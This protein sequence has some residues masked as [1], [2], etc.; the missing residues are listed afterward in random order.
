MTLDGLVTLFALLV[1]GGVGVG[2]AMLFDRFTHRHD[3]LCLC[4]HSVRGHGTWE[5]GDACRYCACPGFV[6]SVRVARSREL[7]SSLTDDTL[8]VE[9][10]ELL[11]GER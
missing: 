3:R 2:A 1:I 9:L 8:D 7:P 5:T 11:G 10:R 4:S 6:D